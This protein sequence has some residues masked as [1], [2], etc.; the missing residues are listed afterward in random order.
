MTQENAS[1]AFADTQAGQV[2]DCLYNPLDKKKKEIRLVKVLPGEGE[3]KIACRLV[4]VSLNE[5]HEFESLSYVWGDDKITLPIDVNG[6][7]LQITTN[8]KCA[9]QNLRLPTIARTIWIDAISIN[10][11]N[12]EEKNEQIP[13]MRQ[14]YT[15]AVRV[16]LWFG[17]QSNASDQALDLLQRLPRSPHEQHITELPFATQSSDGSLLHDDKLSA[18]FRPLDVLTENP[19]WQRI[20]V[21]QEVYLA[22]R[23]VLCYGTR[24]IPWDDLMQASG[25]MMKHAFCCGALGVAIRP[26]TMWILHRFTK[27][28]YRQLGMYERF[29]KNSDLPLS[30]TLNN[31]RFLHSSNPRDKVYGILGL[32]KSAQLEA[33]Y[34][35]SVEA[36]YERA[37]RSII[38]ESGM[39]DVLSQALVSQKS[40]QL[41][42]WVPD[43]SAYDDH[44]SGPKGGSNM[45]PLQG[46]YSACHGTRVHSVPGM[47]GS[48]LLEGIQFDTTSWIS[49]PLPYPT[50]PFPASLPEGSKTSGDPTQYDL[51]LLGLVK[52]LETAVA[53]AALAQSVE[54]AQRLQDD[55]WRILCLD[56]IMDDVTRDYRRTIPKDQETYA[57]LRECLGGS[58]ARNVASIYSISISVVS[59][60]ILRSIFSTKNHRVGVGPM[61]A[62]EG[63]LVCI[64]KGGNLPFILRQNTSTVETPHA[65]FTL[66]GTAY[67]HGVMDGEI[68]QEYE[69]GKGEMQQFCLI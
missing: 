14:I 61:G 3:D 55:F 37:T 29:S 48:I 2:K 6:V 66:V 20:W 7:S 13:Y 23:A 12:V 64:L 1:E 31:L 46:M 36:T 11:T 62:Q 57:E 26:Q 8:L 52:N 39:L 25:W 43:W 56:I 41:P 50:E 22:H 28:T 21:V 54:T 60:H 32:A 19:W 59:N 10:Q 53:D 16:L 45:D 34:S 40:L 68:M 4:T 5:S 42:S 27:Q 69:K 38:T 33:D 17:P 35:L 63:D 30:E 15:S 65:Q 49:P 9:L 44:A 47:D 51:M 58:L 67:V 18:V 24:M